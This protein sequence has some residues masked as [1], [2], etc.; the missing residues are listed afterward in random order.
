MDRVKYEYLTKYFGSYR[1]KTAGGV[2]SDLNK[3]GDEG[4]EL[5]R[6]IESEGIFY[7]KRI[8]K[9]E[10]DIQFESKDLD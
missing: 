10:H 2:D 8:K 5:I 1:T 3:L 7:F 4:W 6:I 9:T